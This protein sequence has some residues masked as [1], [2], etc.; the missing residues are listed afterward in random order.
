MEIMLW[1]TLV[2]PGL[3]YTLWRWGSRYDACRSCGAS[4]LVPVDSPVGQRLM[5]KFYFG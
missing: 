5:K 3:F 4:A 1:T 2:L